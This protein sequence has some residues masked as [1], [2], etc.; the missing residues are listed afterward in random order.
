MVVQVC[1]PSTW[2]VEAEFSKFEASLVYMS[3]KNSKKGEE[4]SR[5]SGK[6]GG[7]EGR[8]ECWVF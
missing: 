1:N 3:Q 4:G 7:K 5:E 6:K 2:E 8:K